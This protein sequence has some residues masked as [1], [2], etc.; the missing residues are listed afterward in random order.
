M[1]GKSFA[2]RRPQPYKKKHFDVR[3]ATAEVVE[4][5]R[6]ETKALV[7]KAMESAKFIRGARVK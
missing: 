6:S 7:G 4:R 1:Q 3:Q 2:A 5:K